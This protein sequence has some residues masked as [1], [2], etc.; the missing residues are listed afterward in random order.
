MDDVIYEEFK[1]QATWKYILTENGRTQGISCYRH[2][3]IRTRREEL[4]LSKD[5]L[6]AVWVLRKALAPL[7]IIEASTTLINRLKKTKNNR[8][9]YENLASMVNNMHM[10]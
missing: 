6:E 1:I 7:D 3:E 2:K 5:E 9:F 8:E 10:S 4:L